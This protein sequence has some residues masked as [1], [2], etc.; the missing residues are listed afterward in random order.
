MSF[1]AG[2][3]PSPIP[4]DTMTVGFLGLGIMGQRMAA[5]LLDDGVDLIVWNRTA[6]KA[7][8]LLEQGATWAAAPDAVGRQIDLAI[9][10]LAH[11]EAVESVA[12]G[13]D[14][15]LAG[16]AAGTLWV[17]CSTVN[18]SFSSSMADEAAAHDVRFMDAPVLGT[19][20]PAASGQLLFVAGATDEDLATVQPL[21]D[22]MGRQT[23]HAGEPG[24]GTSLKMVFNLL[25]GTAMTAFSEGM[26]LGQALGIDRDA[27]MDAVV[28]SIVAPTFLE[29]KRP[30]IEE[31]DYEADFPLKWMHKDL[32]LAA[33]SGYEGGVPM[34]LVNAAKE[35]YAMAVREG[36]GD[37]DFAAIYKLF[38]D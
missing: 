3:F 28:G 2:T 16:M 7:A 13:P 8:S 11:P 17:D 12:L 18:P 22:A 27:L 36:L 31:D 34:P 6:D 25:L 9:T 35:A 21:F 5:N 4:N 33:Q 19:K 32:H 26:A 23:L 38:N 29:Y 37:E 1:H 14:G 15:L 30:K 10:M 20:G 24:M